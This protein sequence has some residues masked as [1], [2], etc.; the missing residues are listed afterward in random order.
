MGDTS[1][2]AFARVSPFNSLFTGELMHLKLMSNLSINGYVN[3]SNAAA[4]LGAITSDF[5]RPTC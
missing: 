1:R 5:F 3:L 4:N 2:C